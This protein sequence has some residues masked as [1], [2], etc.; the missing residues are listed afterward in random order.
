M[1]KP[2]QKYVTQHDLPLLGNPQFAAGERCAQAVASEINKSK[3]P[4]AAVRLVQALCVDVK[5]SK[6]GEHSRLRP[7][8]DRLA[9]DEPAMVQGRRPR[10]AR[11]IAAAAAE[12]VTDK[13]FAAAFV[14]CRVPLQRAADRA[15][16]TVVFDRLLEGARASC[17]PAPRGRGRPGDNHWGPITEKLT[18]AGFSPAAMDGLKL[19]H[20]RVGGNHNW[21][22]RV[23]GELDQLWRRQSLLWWAEAGWSALLHREI[24]DVPPLQRGA[25]MVEEYAHLA[26]ADGGSESFLIRTLRA[27]G[28][29]LDRTQTRSAWVEATAGALGEHAA[30]PSV[31]PPLA[32][33]LKGDSTGFPVTA[34]LAGI[35][36]QAGAE[37][38]DAVGWHRELFRERQV[39]HQLYP[40][41]T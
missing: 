27:E 1:A 38:V 29:P 36:P 6:A 7:L 37:K 2:F 33:V 17:V 24:A 14:A 34:A 41:P 32:A 39:V 30:K 22:V 3:T 5:A 23:E 13:S 10:M 4:E 12:G 18:T 21:L 28:V 16:D 31:P 19:M 40:R 15:Q 11:A 8:V 26:S 9:E 35:K 25:W 20:G